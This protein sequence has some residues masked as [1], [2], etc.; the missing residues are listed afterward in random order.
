[1]SPRVSPRTFYLNEQHEL[2]RAEKEGGGPPPKYTDIN[3]ATKGNKIARSLQ[4]VVNQIEQSPDPSR[5]NHFFLLAAP[6]SQLAKESK[7]KKAVNG[8]LFEQT[9]FA[10]KHSRVFRRL[11]LDLIS[12]ENAGSYET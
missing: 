12:V 5:E 7:A 10:E 8:R 6:V 11:G 3:W 9:D 1:M 2:A 4:R